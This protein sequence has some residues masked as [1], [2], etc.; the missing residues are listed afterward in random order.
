[1][2]KILNK[3]QKYVLWSFCLI[4]VGMLIIALG[5]MTQYVYIMPDA[6]CPETS[7]VYPL[8]E[9]ANNVILYLSIILI[10][11]FAV[12]CIFGNKYRKKY[13]ISNLVVGCAGSTIGI[14]FA[15]TCMIFDIK[16]LNALNANFDALNTFN[17]GFNKGG[18]FALDTA[19]PTAALVIFVIAIIVFAINLA[20]SIVKYI[21]SQNADNSVYLD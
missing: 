20:F 1:M 4:T 13:Y 16:A 11:V 14:A 19:W 21:V 5:Y 9:D 3:A 6:S 2:L 15:V 8:L 18:K 10:V 7:K 17:E 12:M